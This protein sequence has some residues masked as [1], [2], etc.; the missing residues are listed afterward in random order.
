MRD[1]TSKPV[2]SAN[3]SPSGPVSFK[4]LPPD[5]GLPSGILK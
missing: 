4:A 2:V 3:L 1:F 5:G